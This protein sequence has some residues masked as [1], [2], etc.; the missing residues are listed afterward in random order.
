MFCIISIKIRYSFSWTA[1]L[2]LI[3]FH[4]I[5]LP[6]DICITRRS[7]PQWRD[8]LPL[9]MWHETPYLPLR[10]CESHMALQEPSQ[11]FWPWPFHQK[12][13]A[14][15][16]AWKEVMQLHSLNRLSPYLSLY[17]FATAKH[18]PLQPQRSAI[19][20]LSVLSFL[21]GFSCHAQ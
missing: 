9:E 1:S 16:A 17:S 3:N 5:V 14:S 21:T 15:D 18:M 8:T 10:I 12:G 13:L 4:W 7:S 6:K 19:V 2:T 11:C 20:I